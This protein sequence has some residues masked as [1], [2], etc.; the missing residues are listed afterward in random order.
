MNAF[1]RFLKAYHAYYG[2]PRV[3]IMGRNDFETLERMTSLKDH[4]GR[5][6]LR[7]IALEWTNKKRCISIT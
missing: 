7:G 3:A 2:H 6:I 1:V 5:P 4:L